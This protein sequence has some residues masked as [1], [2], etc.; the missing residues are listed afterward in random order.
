MFNSLLRGQTGIEQAQ[1]DLLD[2][3]I[4]CERRIN[5]GPVSADVQGIKY[6]IQGRKA[7]VFIK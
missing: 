5:S 4:E 6:T 3:L 2:K 1:K 7:F